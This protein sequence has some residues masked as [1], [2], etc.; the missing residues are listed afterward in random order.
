MKTAVPHDEIEVIIVDD[1]SD[2]EHILT[3]DMFKDFDFNL[4][5]I[6][7]SKSEKT[8]VN[9]CIAYNL[10]IRAATGDILI[11]QNPE[12]LHV[13]DVIKYT[14]RHIQDMQY[15]SYHC[16][17]TTPKSAKLIVDL[18]TYSYENIMK[19]VN[20]G[21]GGWYNHNIFAPYAYHFLSAIHTHHVKEMRG[22]DERYAPGVAFEDNDFLFRVLLKGLT[23]KYIGAPLCVHL[24]HPKFSELYPLSQQYIQRNKDFYNKVTLKERK[25]L[26]NEN[27]SNWQ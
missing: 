24:D 8:W 3:E 20:D 5:L 11:L 25:W 12:C 1:G 18:D 17:N 16:W 21:D 7:I 15:F 4:K 27:S 10:G 9:S 2:D 26:T 6:S 13:G 14:I 19:I 22:F 23:I